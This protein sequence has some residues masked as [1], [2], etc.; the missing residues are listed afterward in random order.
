MQ[1][2]AIYD[3]ISRMKPFLTAVV[4]LVVVASANAT[5]SANTL[6][7]VG[8]IAEAIYGK[9]FQKARFDVEA[10]ISYV[11]Y[12][13]WLGLAA[14]AVEDSTGAAVVYAER[15][16]IAFG[17]KPGDVVRVRGT[18]TMPKLL[19][20]MA[21]AEDVKP[22]S[23]EDPP[24]A[25][26]ASIS[27]LLDGKYDC[28]LVRTVGKV[29]DVC[30]CNINSQWTYLTLESDGEIL[31]A[32]LPALDA[33]FERL[34]TLVDST[35]R[36]SGL[37]VSS[38][39]SGRVQIG[40]SFKIADMDSISVL[41]RKNSSPREIPDV[42]GI[43]NLRPD[44][45]SALDRHRASGLVMAVWRRG[46]ALLKMDNGTMI[47]VEFDGESVPHCGDEVEVVG[48]PE[49][50]T[51]HVKLVRASWRK[52]GHIQQEHEKPQLVSLDEMVSE[53][54]GDRLIHYDYHGRLVRLR[55]RV[56]N[57]PALGVIDSRLFLETGDGI[58]SVETSPLES[59]LADIEEQSEIEVTGICI[60]ET[61][62]WRPNAMFYKIR[63][64]FIVPRS[65][66]D[67]HV[68]S[69]PPWW[70][71]V[72]LFLVIIALAVALAAIAFWNVM[73]NRIAERRGRELMRQ[74]LQHEK[75]AL[76]TEERTRL[77][78][79]LH[80]SL[81]QNLTGVSMEIE[82]ANELRGAAPPEMLAH[83]GIAGKALKSC[84]DEL[85][86]CLWDL[87][88]QAL[89]ERD[90]AKAVLRTL[91]P[92]MRSA[93]VDVKFDVP[94]S[95]LTDNTAHAILRVVREL[96]INAI[97]HG[98]AT[99]V[100]VRGGIADKDI[101]FTVADNGCG[102][103]PSSHPG[104]TEGHFGLQGIQERVAQLGGK[105]LISSSPSGSSISISIPL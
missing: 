40:R 26:D 20:C 59:A 41:S 56:L 35:V 24:K 22:I 38:D 17:L 101:A 67:I 79:E 32:S 51:L 66:A 81:S 45:I 46:Q 53:T 29:R 44:E 71:P 90:M 65:E 98:H 19:F 34:K 49:S 27:D 14:F 4:I 86:N 104:V 61:E 16:V 75:A 12:R 18:T 55:G 102:F 63:G 23:H 68:L 25:V 93:K 80:D 69:R 83:L 105:V 70:T 30:Q 47:G 73:L 89:E 10:K 52:L 82:A 8:A 37:C 72:R 76:K 87:R 33:D 92:H 103:N 100:E 58:I 96:V 57:R 50:D 95:K 48:F 43:C 31:Y 6:Q 97:R 13:D 1:L 88:S 77:A 9:S 7:S 94:R 2:V 99:S 74:R 39:T 62:N 21:A 15:S 91:Q 5:N 42:T 84:R 3:T 36:V 60:M 11:R 28:R 54:N 85:R 64:F 78:V